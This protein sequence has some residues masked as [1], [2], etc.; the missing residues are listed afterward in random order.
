MPG[1]PTQADRDAMA[2]QTARER[3]PAPAIEP[4]VAAAPAEPVQR[5]LPP[6]RPTPTPAPEPAPTAA[7]APRDPSLQRFDKLRDEQ[8]GISW[9][10]PVEWQPTTEEL[11]TARRLA[12]GWTA[13]A[14]LRRPQSLTDFVRKNGGLSMDTP[15]AGDLRAADAG[16]RIGLLRRQGVQADW[17]AQRAADAGYRFG[18]ET[19]YG[20]GIDVD[21]FIRALTEDAGGRIKH[22]PDN[23]DTEAWRQQQAMAAEVHNYIHDV[24]GLQ[25]KDMDPRRI[26]WIL[27]QEPEAARTLAL[28]ERADRLSWDG[29]LELA[30][31]LDDERA[32]AEHD[33]APEPGA[34]EM[35]DHR[36]LPAPDRAEVERFYEAAKGE[37]EGATSPYRAGEPVAA[38]GQP[39]TEGAVADR[40]L[41]SARAEGARAPQ[42]V[43]RARS[44]GDDALV[45]DRLE[46]LF[47][48]REGGLRP[49]TWVEFGRDIDK[50][51]QGEWAG[52][53]ALRLGHTSQA[54][55]LAGLPD[56]WLVMPAD[57]PAKAVGDRVA[58]SGETHSV[59]L[60]DLKRLPDHLERPVAIFR[61]D[62]QPNAYVAFIDAHDAK[63]FPVMA[64]IH[65][66]AGQI[67]VNRVLSVYGRIPRRWFADQIGKGNLLYV[68]TVKSRGLEKSFGVQ[69][70]EPTNLRGSAPPGS[71][72]KVFTQADLVKPDE[73][74]FSPRD[75]RQE[76]FDFGRSQRSEE[77]LPLF[78]G[79][80]RRPATPEPKPEQPTPRPAPAGEPGDLFA[81]REP[82]QP[83]PQREPAKPRE[84]A[85]E[86][87]MLQ[88]AG[89]KIGGARKDRWAERGLKLS[90][91]EGMSEGEAY[92]HVTKDAVW[93]KPDY[94]AMV[95]AGMEPQVAALV[96]ILRDRLGSRPKDDSPAGR[97]AFVTMM[98][99][100]REA[101]AN[102]KTPEDFR[103]ARNRLV[104]DL[105]GYPRDRYAGIPAKEVRD[106]LFSV[107][108]GRN[109]PF[110]IHY[111]DLRKAQEMLEAG[112]P[113]KVEPWTRRYDIRE[114][115]DGTFIVVAKGTGKV[116]E[117][118]I[119]TRDSAEEF[120]RSTYEASLA[121][122]G[123]EP[124]VPER[125]HLDEIQRI[126]ADI[127]NGRNVTGED[128]VNDFGFRGV[129]FGNWV[130]SDERQRM[131][132]IA[133]DALH[134]MAAVIGVP[135]K[136]L[137]LDGQLGLA[138]GARGSGGARAHYE[139]SR[140]V[141][142]M[143]KLSGAGSLA[144]EWAHAL[145]HYF[146]VLDTQGG[147]G[148]TRGASG[149]YDRTDSRIK[150]LSNL[151]PSMAEAFD[152]VM[153]AIF[154]RDWTRAENVRAVEL[155]MEE[156]QAD[157]ARQK[158]RVEKA[159][160]RPHEGTEKF[161]KQSQDWID[162][163][164]R[165]LQ[166][167]RE[168]LAILRDESKPY[169]DARKVNSSYF[170]QANKLSG[171]AG[172]RGYWSR[173]TEMFARA[174]E[175]YI[176]DKVKEQGGRSDYLVHGVEPERYRTGY[177]GNPYP[178]SDR[179]AI[180]AAFD[181]LFETM[182]VREGEKGPALFS[183]RQVETSEFKRWFGD[184]KVRDGD[185]Q[186]LVMWH[187]SPV[188]GFT[189]F[190]MSKI[191]PNDPD[192]RVN[193]FWFS[194][195][196]DE[197]ET[198]GQF[199]WGRR[200]APDA[201]T[202]PF[203][204]AIKNPAS[205][206][207][208]RA[209]VRDLETAG[210]DA[211]RSEVRAELEKRGFDG[212]WHRR[213]FRPTPEQIREFEQT[214]R[215]QITE[216]RWL[217]HD[218][219][220]NDVNLYDDAVGGHVTGWLTLQEFLDTEGDT[221]VA[222][223][224]EQIK[225][226]T[227]NVGTFDPNND[228][229]R[230]SP[231][232]TGD[233][234]RPLTPEQKKAYENVGR[235]VDQ[236]GL[237]DR[238]RE[239]KQDW[240]KK[241]LTQT[242]DSYVGLKDKDPEGYMAARMANSSAPAQAGFLELGTL[243][244]DGNTYALKDRNGGVQEHLARP[245]RE[246]ADD[247]LWWVAAHRAERLKAED[248]E[249][250]FS[251]ADI[252]AIKSTN[253]GRLNFDYE[254]L[255]GSTTRSREAAY[256]DSL[257]K[258]EEFNSNVMD[259]A[260]ES[261]LVKRDQANALLANP[262]YVPFYRIA[263]QD[264]SRAFVGPSLSSGFVKQNAFKKLK[265]GSEKLNNDLWENA[266]GNWSHMIDA[267]LRNKVA[268]Q[269]LDT[270]TRLG[271]A[272]ELTSQEALHEADKALKAKTSWVMEDGQKKY[273]AVEDPFVFHA[274]TA[275]E[276]GAP[277][278]PLMDIGRWFART[279]RAGVTSNPL[280]A[281]RMLVRDTENVIGIAHVS[282]NPI[283][284][285]R[286]GFAQHDLSGALQNVARAIGGRDLEPLKL[287]DTAAN[288]FVGG[289]LMRLGSG[290]EGG[291]RRTTAENIL[292]NE[293]RVRKF[294]NRV[295]DVGRAYKE[296]ASVGED[297][298]RLA[299]YKNAI[300]AGAS[301][302]A[303][304][305]A[306]RDV[307]D[308]TLKG[309]AHWVRVLTDVT[310]FL[311]A[312]AQGLYKIGRVAADADRSVM[313]AVGG[314]MG[315]SLAMRAVAVVGAM[316]LA[317]L[318]LAGIYQDDPDWKNR[319]D[320]D[321]NLNYWFKVGD[322]EFRIPKGFEMAALSRLLSSGVEAFFS[323]EMTGERWAGNFWKILSQNLQVQLPAIAQPIYDVATNQTALGRPLVPKGLENLLPEER[324]TSSTTMPSRW[325]ASALN[326][327]TRAVGMNVGGVSPIQ[328]D[329]LVNGYGG[330]A[331]ASV[332][333]TADMIVRPLTDEPVQPSRDW[334]AFLSQG[335]VRTEPSSSSRYID[336]LYRQGQQVEQAWATYQNMIKEGHA[337]EAR[338]FFEANKDQ[339]RRHG[340]ISGVMRLEGDLNR[341]A[342]LITN[343]PDPRVT[344]EQK[345]DALRRINEV[346]KR[347]AEGAFRAMPQ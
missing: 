94:A 89:E 217:Q 279:L 291:I 63:G 154:K 242:V 316:A 192:A 47:S 170:D 228:D 66:A 59:S 252:A 191:N 40:F 276:T 45:G 125:P 338:D 295:S 62:T 71:S 226:A 258:L 115:R 97:R 303:A 343:H 23:H 290:Q 15:E 51:L 292:D 222:F 204:L 271:D 188:R 325:A 281:A 167:M 235:S 29:S 347:A 205:P 270:T 46:P 116:L 117:R 110:S 5:A 213:A 196:R 42:E 314:R 299:V 107:Y 53:K 68:D 249:N 28:A 304:S 313:A 14:D 106:V 96:K 124:A 311:N 3:P 38:Q 86:S 330:W 130:A 341:Q 60:E 332:L 331:A 174:F 274:V 18:E 104:Y 119:D 11:S 78:G 186:P 35:A 112:F 267:A 339:L 214:G 27:R 162:L 49:K 180:N 141:I 64:A 20:N 120:A 229:I 283:K 179:P 150:D 346:R 100:V 202:R 81:A 122:N 342:R 318:A 83:E 197:A 238:L 216:G 264:S 245:L 220:W 199:P 309:A 9:E 13:E 91:L 134:D 268:R 114:V 142:N 345:A 43:P 41:A 17:M 323:P 143:T 255:D 237:L 326:A 88:D 236:P 147:K 70:P 144:H 24:V 182:D 247:F 54:L 73:P 184:S 2:A 275:L 231:R 301:H 219:K 33:T 171:K 262:F 21:A 149:W 80:E 84:T 148:Q 287:S 181:H 285:L 82:Q 95:E 10:P 160:E 183:P 151:R 111:K 109:E 302:E 22:Y 243:K 158:E 209:A 200:N 157:I 39:A 99:H 159:K 296:A 61:S 324:F 139:P 30:R 19:T 206:R 173:P 288:A 340:I 306:A 56:K 55:R 16:G 277:R 248:R 193:G 284:N 253:R 132:N 50:V 259:L 344:A 185:G 233:S 317:D 241:V 337:A 333:R 48:P 90:D 307:Q 165:R 266:I 92:K 246:E 31:R 208:V 4:P 272:R 129:E 127:R 294:W 305:F 269:I 251:D 37:L 87:T 168:R 175:S 335:M 334:A 140:L 1:E 69:F 126:G 224:P 221:V 72:R 57:V 322:T 12:R 298:N 315:K 79:G 105:V 74:L 244:F 153:R 136:A 93:P 218:P 257:K 34:Y 138:F 77:G 261:G 289:G 273:Y 161:L 250:L 319:T 163:R 6:E 328:L 300:D 7:P 336:L 131:V 263:E 201:E 36:D 260:V 210:L 178:D 113:E 156:V 76:G 189:T 265:G 118:G 207:D 227:N 297:I 58:R 102:V 32:Q 190:D 44:A 195:L 212:Y 145:D 8:G 155:M 215:L 312:R 26:A 320:D 176:F 98:N 172:E 164:E 239:M 230:Y 152:Q 133:Y 256:A 187:G 278:G 282:Y 211:T 198:A 234:G 108:K 121:K 232:L 25:P 123:G 101:Y 146:G 177:K 327:I 223:R 128:F 293:A 240:R 135:V 65:A 194:S 225:S 280:F 329:Y 254:M 75:R 85:R 286:D 203:F 137:S 321:I 166:A 52:S 169:T 103:D 310:P 67:T 308:F